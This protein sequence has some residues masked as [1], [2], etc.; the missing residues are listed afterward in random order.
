[1]LKQLLGEAPQALQRGWPWTVL[2]PG[3]PCRAVGCAGHWCV[4]PADN[5]CC[6][7]VAMP[8]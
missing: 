8:L 3:A 4:G 7:A 1:M 2:G 5:I 6:R